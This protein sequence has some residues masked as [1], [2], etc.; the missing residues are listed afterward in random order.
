M[1]YLLAHPKAT[2]DELM[3]F[4]KGPDFLLVGLFKELMGFAQLMKM[5]VVASLS[6]R[7]LKLNR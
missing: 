6:V 2:L 5:D 1:V 7:K 4:V 3:D